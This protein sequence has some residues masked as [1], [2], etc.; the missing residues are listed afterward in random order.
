MSRSDGLKVSPGAAKRILK[1][2]WPREDGK[3]LAQS[4]QRSNLMPDR[5]LH[6]RKNTRPAQSKQKQR[7]T[8]SE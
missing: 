8:N 1:K 7:E 5:A 2:H 4:Y 6:S 3:D